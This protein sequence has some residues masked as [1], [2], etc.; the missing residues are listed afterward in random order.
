MELNSD[1]LVELANTAMPFGRYQGRRLIDL[2]EPYLVWF[3]NKGFPENRLGKLLALALFIRTEGLEKLVRP[4]E[5]PLAPA[6]AK[7]Q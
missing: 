2:P 3:A 4:L 7:L 5:K 1:V 6:S